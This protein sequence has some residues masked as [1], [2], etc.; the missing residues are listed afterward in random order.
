MEDRL[1]SRARKE[2]AALS[3]FQFRLLEKRARDQSDHALALTQ[4]TALPITF[5]LLPQLPT[6]CN[7]RGHYFECSLTGGSYACSSTES[8]IHTSGAWRKAVTA[9]LEIRRQCHAGRRHVVTHRRRQGRQTE[10]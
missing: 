9:V 5:Q 1:A 6:G 4:F 8:E 3:G 10:V 7:G 2:K